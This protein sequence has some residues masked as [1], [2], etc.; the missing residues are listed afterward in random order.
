MNHSLFIIFVF[1]LLFQFPKE[2]AAQLF[3]GD[4]TPK[5]DT[6]YIRV[7]KDELTTRLYLSRKQNGYSLSERLLN[8]WIKYRTNDNLL[9]GIG[10]TY[11]FLTLNLAVK[12]PF[13]NVDDD[14][15]GKSKYIDFQGHTIF[16]SYIFD[17]Y[18]QWNKGFY[19]A[20]PEDVY[21]GSWNALQMPQRPDMRTNLVGL[22]IQYL[23]NSE[24]YSYKAAFVQ[25]ELQRKSAGSPIVGADT[26]WMLGMTDS[27]TV[28][29]DIP[30]IGYLDN[31]PFNQADVFHLGINGGYAYTFVW[32]EKLYLS[33]STTI[34]LSGGVNHIHYTPTSETLISNLTIG[35]NNS[36]RIS[37]GYNSKDYY[38]G[39]SYIHLR[40]ANRVTGGGEWMGYNTGNIRV[41]F[42]KRFITK[43]PIKLLRPD[44][45]EF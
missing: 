15:Y 32:Q 25:N 35:F 17:F 4:Y 10:Y 37:F 43:R 1:I 39:L 12:F 3:E 36:T 6:S 34:G 44:L 45:W 42:V 20:N 11:S 9:L 28:G 16:R 33:L 19:I 29:G 7:Y 30:P 18:L 22:N 21:D 14:V 13:L 2:G 8:P 26:Y 31:E 38:V 23:F 27:A 24:R 40:M 5:Y 41:N